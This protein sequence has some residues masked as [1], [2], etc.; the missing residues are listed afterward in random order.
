MNSLSR[1]SFSRLLALSPLAAQ[2]AS[3]PPMPR[4]RL[5]RIDFQATILG[6]GAQRIG[7]KITEDATSD[8]VVIEAIEQGVN[9]IDTAPN[10]EES[11]VRLGRALKGRRDKIFLTSKIETKTKEEALGQIR[12]SLRRL[13][14]DHLDCVLFH[15]IG[16]DDRFP[17]FDALLSARGGLGGLI[18]A[19]KQGMIRHIGCSTHSAPARV[20]RAFN[21]GE[22]EVLMCPLN[23]V[24]VHT[25]NLETKLLP[26]ARKRNIA[27]IA[28]KVLGGPMNRTGARL[29]SPE[30]Y[31]ATMRYAWSV[32]GV[33]SAVIGV[34]NPD[35]LRMALDAARSFKPLTAAEAAALSKRGKALAAEWGPTFGG[36]S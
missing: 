30:D 34:R 12:E 3:A 28:M 32:P 21:T 14:T 19:K 7:E 2:A 25:Y 27:I 4:R 13:Q 16:R 26:E 5:G 22:F 10:Y 17:D 11:E 29:T 20:I 36:V 33:A 8:R 9:Y 23:F 6:L 24:S 18:E 15:N 35:Q 1:R 31:V